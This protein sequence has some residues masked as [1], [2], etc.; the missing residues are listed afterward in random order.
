[1]TLESRD[2]GYL[3]QALGDFLSRLPA[4]AVVKVT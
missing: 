2:H 3:E 4:D 1:V